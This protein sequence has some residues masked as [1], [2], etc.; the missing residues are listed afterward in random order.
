MRYEQDTYVKVFSTYMRMRGALG[1]L[2]C[3]HELLLQ[4]TCRI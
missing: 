4:G 2:R 3:F 1:M